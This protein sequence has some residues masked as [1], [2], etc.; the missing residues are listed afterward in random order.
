LIRVCPGCGDERDQ[1]ENASRILLAR[2]QAL[3]QPQG[4]EAAPSS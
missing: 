1:D 4:A 2:G 3:N